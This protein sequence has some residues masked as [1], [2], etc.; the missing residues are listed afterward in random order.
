LKSL[1]GNVLQQLATERRTG[2]LA[3]VM[4][5]ADHHCRVFMREGAIYHIAC[6]RQ[7]HSECL[8]FIISGDISECFFIPN[9]KTS[10][11]QTCPFT[12]DQIIGKLNAHG[13]LVDFKAMSGAVRDPS[14]SSV[15]GTTSSSAGNALDFQRIQEGIKV[16]LIR[17]IGPVGARIMA[18]VMEQKWRVLSPTKEDIADLIRILQFEIDDYESRTEFVIETKALL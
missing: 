16:A 14:V 7:S 9:L 1:L 18:R 15:R 8:D 6:G 10:S 13:V 2:Q 17:Q 12:T 4:K 3:I 5:G 11:T